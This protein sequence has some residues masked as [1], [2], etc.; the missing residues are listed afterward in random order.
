MKDEDLIQ[1]LMETNKKRENPVDEAILRQILSI[2]ILHPLEEDR[3]T[4]QDQ[5]LYFIRQS[6]SE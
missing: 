2:V 5:M 6:E 4:S 1:V 3:G